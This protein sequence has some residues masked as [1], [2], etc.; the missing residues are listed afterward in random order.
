VSFGKKY[1]TRNKN[2]EPK[3]KNPFPEPFLAREMEK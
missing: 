2:V 3:A 1:Y